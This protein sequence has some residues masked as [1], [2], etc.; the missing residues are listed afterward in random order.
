MWGRVPVS[1]LSLWWASCTQ[2]YLLKNSISFSL[3]WDVTYLMKQVPKHT[4]VCCGAYC[5]LPLMSLIFLYQHHISLKLAF[6]R[7]SSYLVGQAPFILFPFSEVD[8]FS[9]GPLCFCINVRVRLSKFTKIGQLYWNSLKYGF[10]GEAELPS[11]QMLGWPILEC[12][13]F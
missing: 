8:F 1:V 9:H 12:D 3:K 11:L 6:C 10:C 7:I 2:Y 13:L 5:P 4:W